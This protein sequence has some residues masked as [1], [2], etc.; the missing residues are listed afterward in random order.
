MQASE[1][2]HFLTGLPGFGGGT[3]SW[4]ADE[5][6]DLALLSDMGQPIIRK[7]LKSLPPGFQAPGQMGISREGSTSL[8]AHLN[9][10]AVMPSSGSAAPSPAPGVHCSCHSL[11]H[12]VRQSSEVPVLPSPA[13]PLKLIEIFTCSPQEAAS[14]ATMPITSLQSLYADACD[15]CMCSPYGP[16]WGSW[17]NRIL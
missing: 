10:S 17:P 14:W 11:L 8:P 5:E 4:D 1:G 2:S 12:D 9:R 15:G 6:A 7:G 13:C 3:D 16:D